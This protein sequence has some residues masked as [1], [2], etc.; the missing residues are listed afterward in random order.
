MG[1]LLTGRRYVVT[2]VLNDESLA[3]HA[4]AALLEHGGEVLLTS[5]GRTMRITRRVAARLGEGVD[6][7]E[8]DAS[9]AG[10][11]P[12][13]ADAVAA[14]WDSVDG[15]VHAIARTPEDARDGRFLDTP[16]ESAESTFR[17]S[18]WSLQGLAAALREL[19]ERSPHGASIVALDFDAGRAWAGY[20]WMG[21][22]KAALEAVG[23]YLALYLGPSR[24][25][26]NLVSPGPIETVSGLSERAF[27]SY[28]DRWADAPLGWDTL[29]PAIVAGPIV[30]LMS[31]LA[32]GITGEIL[33]VDGGYHV[34]GLPVPTD[35][36]S[37]S[38]RRHHAVD[39]QPVGVVAPGDGRAELT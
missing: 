10:D 18:A 32:R 9:Q 36:P 19:L 17:V 21:V 13:L 12:R 5:F 38:R 31:D 4:A 14:R 3:Y 11:Y 33:H 29:D 35:W 39:Q 7:L 6:V 28:A 30:F 37:R 1:E 15:L 34:A 22:S 26:V 27:G 16:P 20:D 23:R 2:G 24:V 8:L 25:R